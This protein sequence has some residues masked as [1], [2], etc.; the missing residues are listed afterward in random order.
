MRNGN[1]AEDE[2]IRSLV[3]YAS[4]T[5]AEKLALPKKDLDNLIKKLPR[6][7]S[8]S[9]KM[10][11]SNFIARDPDMQK[12]GAKGLYGGGVHVDSY[13]QAFSDE[14]G[15]LDLERLLRAAATLL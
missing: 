1:W 12:I 8:G 2:M 9:V 7:S 11:I 14:S 15:R 6:R 13:W 4:L 5:T 10:R 3:F